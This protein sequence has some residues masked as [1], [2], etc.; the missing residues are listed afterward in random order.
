[1]PRLACQRCG[2]QLYSVAILAAMHPD[3][4][5]CP[6]CGAY[7]D[8][9]RREGSRR[10]TNRRENPPDEPGPPGGV[11]RRVEDRRADRLRRSAETQVSTR[12]SSDGW[13]D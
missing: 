2:R 1:M 8:L 9:D 4:R 3:E 5:R 13:Q 11:E 10:E 12:R 7:F 6:R